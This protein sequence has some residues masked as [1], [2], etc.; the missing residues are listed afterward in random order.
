MFGF[1]AFGFKL[2]MAAIAGGAL[3]YMPGEETRNHK[4]VESSLICIFGAAILGLTSQLHFGEFNIVTGIGILAVILV[5]IS[6]SKK[7]DF[8]NRMI[9]L[10]S[11]V[12]GM[13]IGA[14]FVL[15]ALMLV[16]LVYIILR[17]SEK[18]LNYFDQ[19]TDQAND[20]SIENVSNKLY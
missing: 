16:G 8:V 9:W 10:F 18:L 12:S 19:D 15:Q 2:L 17:N 4:M 20:N 6:I 5:I 7:L 11:G 14:G 1:I 3:S 13:I